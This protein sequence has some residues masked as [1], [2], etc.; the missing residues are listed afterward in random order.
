MVSASTELISEVWG[1]I[2]VLAAEPWQGSASSA[3]AAAFKHGVI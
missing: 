3:S 2:W 1:G